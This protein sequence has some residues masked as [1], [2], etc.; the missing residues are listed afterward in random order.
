MSTTTQPKLNL[1][2]NKSDCNSLPVNRLLILKNIFRSLEG[3]ANIKGK[4]SLND[5]LEWLHL[6]DLGREKLVSAIDLAK[7]HEIHLLENVPDTYE[8]AAK[9]VRTGAASILA[10]AEDAISPKRRSGVSAASE[11]GA[12]AAK[13]LGKRGKSAKTEPQKEAKQ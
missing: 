4:A 12:D 6:I 1:I 8:N 11:A 7:K 13:S 5:L 9:A 10:A 3:M 2:S